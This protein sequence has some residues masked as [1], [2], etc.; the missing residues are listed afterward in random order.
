MTIT[1]PGESPEYRAARNR[2]L[3]EEISLRRAM[4]SVAIARRNLP[5]GGPVPEDYLFD[6][7]DP[8]GNP[9]KIKL[10]QL[11]TP[12]QKSLVVYN[13][14]FPRWS[15]DSRPGPTKGA[16]A[17]LKLEDS[18]CPSCTALLDS[19]DPTAIHFA[20]S[21]LNFVVIAKAPIERIATYARE[22][23]WKNLRLLSSAGNNFKRD[24]QAENSEGDQLPLMTVFHR[25][26]DQIRLFWSSE[27]MFAPT[28]PGQDPRHLGTLDTIWNIFDMTPEGRPP[29]WD[30]QIDYDC[31]HPHNH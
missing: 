30:E 21:G 14:M 26:G 3:D 8:N 22:R 23:G 28:D 19:L 31:C 12:E 17:D 11:F 16:T 10:S 7:I 2:L 15:K 6:T 20:P 4:E 24:Y 5:P 25:D 27:L 9:E 1:F 18:P 29:A 13:F